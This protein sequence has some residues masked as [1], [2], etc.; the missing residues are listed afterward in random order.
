[1]GLFSLGE[2]M[3]KELKFN[4]EAEIAEVAKHFF[5][6]RGWTLYPEVVIDLFNGR[7]DYMGVK[8]NT[9]CQSIEC[10]KTLTYPVIEQLIRWQID[11]EKRKKWTREGYEHKI[12]IPHLLVAFVG[13]KNKGMEDLQRM[14]LKQHK[15]GVYT[16]EKRPNMRT[17]ILK[18][19]PHF[20][21]TA[22]DYWTLNLG[23]YSYNIREEIAPR[24]QP[25]SRQTAHRIIESL[26]PDMQCVDTGHSGKVGGYMT[27]F[28]R[29]MNK[30]SDILS[31]GKERH[32]QHIIDELNENG[33]H[34]YCSDKVAA[35]SITKFIDQFKMAKRS[36]DYGPWFVVEKSEAA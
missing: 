9:L 23:E 17:R 21:V 26:N 8:N 20:D 31:D 32:I 4:N 28:K 22:G 13:R 35:S 10:K 2:I 24:L 16:V 14:L 11:A 25:G 33:G 27:P 3:A 29:T 18:K 19:E 15:V 5:E 1:M 34:H 30:V 6:L 36:R 7:P 12:A